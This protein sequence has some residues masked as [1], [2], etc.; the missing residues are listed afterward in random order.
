MADMFLDKFRSLVPEY[1]DD[2]WQPED[3]LSEDE[4]EEMV[5]DSLGRPAAILPQAVREFYLSV[6]G[7]EDL[8]EA[9]YFV[10]EPD[11]FEIE[12][13]YL[14]FMEDEEEKFVWGIREDQLSVPDPLVHRR[15]NVTGRWMSEDGTFSEY[16]LDMYSWV[17]EELEPE[18]EDQ[19]ES[20]G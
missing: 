7:V 1:L 15:N 13:G 11:E 10:W 12:D 6:G 9:Y 17:F 5:Q 8:M 3:G 20:Q 19:P 2:K 14:L 4:L 18:L 16:M